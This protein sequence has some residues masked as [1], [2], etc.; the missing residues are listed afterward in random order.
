MDSI[1]CA[2]AHSRAGREQRKL[3][4]SLCAP[5]QKTLSA[6]MQKAFLSE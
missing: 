6:I 3:L 2:V 1:E 4:I 5:V